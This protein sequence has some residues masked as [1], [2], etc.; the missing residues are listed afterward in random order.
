M[1]L[2]TAQMMTK[3]IM[4]APVK[5]ATIKELLLK[6]RVLQRKRQQTWTTALKKSQ[7]KRK[8]KGVD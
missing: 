7:T 6:A 4:I 3:I 1:A 5:T 2:K 8:T